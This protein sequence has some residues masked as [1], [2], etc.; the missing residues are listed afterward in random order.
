MNNKNNNN[1]L[2]NLKGL[3]YGGAWA[4]DSKEYQETIQR[5]IHDKGTRLQD[6]DTNRFLEAYKDWFSSSHNI[7]GL[8]SFDSM[9]CSLGTTET[10]DKFYIANCNLRLR[11][12]KGEYFY[13]QMAARNVFADWAWIG[14]E[15][16][17]QGDVV[18]VS[19]PFADTGSVPEGLDAVLEQ[20]D[21]QSVPVLVDLAYINLATNMAIDLSRECIKVIT[22][23]LSKVFPVPYHR[24]GMRMTKGINDDLMIAYQQNQYVNKFGSGL[25]MELIQKYEPTHTHNSYKQRQENLCRELDIN[26]SPCVIFGIDDKQKHTQYNRGGNTNRLCFSKVWAE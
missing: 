6:I 7:Q 21:Q 22:T 9:T 3:P 11:I 8:G 5:I 2:P 10:F 26:V 24:V 18:M 4:I 23:S 20:C 16:I 13:H 15:P 25:G 12:W 17:A 14:D 19:L 1:S